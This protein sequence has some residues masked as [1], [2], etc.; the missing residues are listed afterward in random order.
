VPFAETPATRNTA[1]TSALAGAKRSLAHVQRGYSPLRRRL[2]QCRNGVSIRD[3]FSL[4]DAAVPCSRPINHAF[5][6]RWVGVILT[7]PK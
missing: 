1:E 2:R 4:V 5:G 6:E 7:D 3:Y